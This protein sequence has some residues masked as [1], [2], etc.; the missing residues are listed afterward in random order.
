[1][2]REKRPEYDHPKNVNAGSDLMDAGIPGQIL[3][4]R[5]FDTDGFVRIWDGRLFIRR[6]V[7]VWSGA[8]WIAKPAKVW[9]GSAW[10][11]A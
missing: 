9:N 5:F 2:S 11:K 6:V 4:E 8:A 10:V 3:S 7:K 1:M